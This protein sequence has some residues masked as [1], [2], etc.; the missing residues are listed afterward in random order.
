MKQFLGSILLVLG[1]LT[2]SACGGDYGAPKPAAT[3]PPPSKAGEVAITASYP[4]F[5]PSTITVTKGQTIQI[6]VS[7]T[8]T[9]HTF[10]I[11]ELGINK[12]V[13]RGETITWEIRSDKVGTF[14]FYCAI[15]GHR[16]A[17]ME[18]TLK[19]TE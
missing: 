19:V 5:Q 9:N 2:G 6:K 14:T 1:V 15:P 7:A 4:R 10:T 13:G 17:G 16:S 8:D 12:A 18:G 3:T 11:D